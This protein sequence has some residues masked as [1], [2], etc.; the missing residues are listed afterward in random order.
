MEIDPAVKNA[1]THNHD[2]KPDRKE[3]AL[4]Y[5]NAGKFT[6]GVRPPT[7]DID[8]LERWLPYIN[9]DPH[10]TGVLTGYFTRLNNRIPGNNGS[11]SELIRMI[12]R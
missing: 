7:V 11:S 2:E 3:L 5:D 6:F 4:L 12:Y 10:L 9:N 1:S 8:V